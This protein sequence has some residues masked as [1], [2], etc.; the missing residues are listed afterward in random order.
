MTEWQFAQL[1]SSDELAQLHF[2][3]MKKHQPDGDIEFAITV[4]EYAER[5]TQ[6]MR[7]F[8]QAD[9]MVNQKT[10]PFRP[11]GWGESLLQALSECMNSVRRYPYE[12]AQEESQ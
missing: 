10:A 4:K 2:F 8:A 12:P 9:K 11:F 6:F 1:D 5:N 7:Y 3:S